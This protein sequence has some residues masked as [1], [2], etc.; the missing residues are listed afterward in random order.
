[1]NIDILALVREGIAEEKNRKSGWKY[2]ALFKDRPGYKIDHKYE[3]AREVDEHIDGM[4]K[5]ELLRRLQAA[6][7]RGNSHQA[8]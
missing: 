8:T 3:K 1:M 4:S 5:V 7:D 6:L 2:P